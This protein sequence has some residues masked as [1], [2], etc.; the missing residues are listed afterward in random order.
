MTE[1]IAGKCYETEC[2]NERVK[3]QIY[4]TEHILLRNRKQDIYFYKKAI[5]QKRVILGS[6][7]NCKPRLSLVFAT[8]EIENDDN[9][10]NFRIVYKCECCD[11][12]AKYKILEMDQL[13]TVE[14]E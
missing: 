10:I 11:R 12:T 2:E 9:V 5:E 8:A 14:M 4:C 3:Y 7:D 6:C 13:P 1:Q